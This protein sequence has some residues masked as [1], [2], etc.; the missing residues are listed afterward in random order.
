MRSRVRTRSPIAI[1]LLIEDDVIAQLPTHARDLVV[2]AANSKWAAISI[3][4]LTNLSIPTVFSERY[5]RL[6][7]AKRQTDTK[8]R[9]DSANGWRLRRDL[10]ATGISGTLLE[11]E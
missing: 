6:L 5:A 7:P 10:I 2:I 8:N 3:W 1:F 9:T 11:K 4:I